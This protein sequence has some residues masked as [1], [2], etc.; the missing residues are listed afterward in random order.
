MNRQLS[1]TALALVA[2]LVAVGCAQGNTSQEPEPYS[3]AMLLA[4]KPAGTNALIIRALG[5]GQGTVTISDPSQTCVALDWDDSRHYS[6]VCWAYVPVTTASVTVAAEASITSRFTGWGTGPCAGSTETSCVV[7]MEKD[8]V[9]NLRFDRAG[10]TPRSE[11]VLTVH[12]LGSIDGE[13][14]APESVGLLCAAVER[15]SFKQ[16]CTAVVPNTT[17]PTEVTLT[18]TPSVAGTEFAGWGGNCSGTGTC[19]VTVDRDIGVTAGFARTPSSQAPVVASFSASPATIATGGSAT[20]SWSVTNATS[21]RI[22]PGIGVVTGS[23]VAVA[24]SSTTTYTLTA[25]NAIGTT[26]RMATVTVGAAPRWVSIAAHTS[27]SA[28]I[29]SDQTLWGWGSN[30]RG[31]IGDGTRVSRYV[32][33]LVGSGFSAVSLGFYHSVAL[34]TDGTVWAWGWNGLGTVGDGTTIE[35]IAPVLVGSGFSAIAAGE[36]HSF[37]LRPD[38][39]MWGWGYNEFGQLGDGT[40]TNRLAPVPL[41]TGFARVAAGYHHSVAIKAD[42]TLWSWGDNMYGQL[43]DGSP[44][45]TLPAQVGADTN[46][47]SVAAGW[48]HTAAIKADGSLWTWGGNASG[49]LG[50]GTTA[51]RSAPARVGTGYASVSVGLNHTAAIK[52]DGTLWTWGHNGWGQLGD[53]TKTTRTTPTQVGTGFVAVAAGSS[54]TL[55]LKDDGTLWSWGNNASGQLGDGTTTQRS[56]PGTV[57][58]TSTVAPVATSLVFSVEPQHQL[59]N[60]ARIDPPVRVTVLDQY[61]APYTA[62]SYPITISITGMSIGS[63]TGTTTVDSALGV[64]TFADLEVTGTAVRPR[65][66]AS[67]PGLEVATSGAFELIDGAPVAL[68]LSL[69][70]PTATA[71]EALGDIVVSATNA[72]GSPVPLTEPVTLSV[73]SGPAGGA[74]I[75][76]TTVDPVGGV[77]TFSGIS[78]EVAGDYVL[79][80][81]SGS[82]VVNGAVTV[83]PAV[84]DTTPPWVFI[85]AP[86]NDATVPGSFVLTASVVDDV[87]VSDLHLVV[88]GTQIASAFVE[89]PA[90]V[91]SA[92]VD[93]LAAGSHVLQVCAV[94]TSGNLGCSSD[95]V[96]IV[97]S[98]T[99]SFTPTGSLATQRSWPVAA[100]LADGRVLVM[101][102]RFDGLPLLPS[103]ADAELYDPATGTFTPTGSLDTPRYGFTATLL[104][105]GRVLVLGG[106]NNLNN[107]GPLSSAE[108]YDPASGVFTPAGNMT[109]PRNHHSATLLD[110]GR[111]LIAGTADYSS[112][113]LTAVGSAELFDPT[114]GGFTPTG[115]M[116]VARYFHTATLLPSGKVFIA[117]GAARGVPL[118]V[119]DALPLADAELYDPATG[120]FSATGTMGVERCFHSATM[121]PSG[122]VLIAGGAAGFTAELYDPATG[123]LAVTGNLATERFEHTATLLADGTV[124]LAGGSDSTLTNTASAELF[125][126]DLGSFTPTGSMTAA[127]R[128]HHAAS[129]PDGAVLVVGGGEV[130]P[131]AE[132]YR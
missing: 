42:G 57:G 82:A 123:T 105:D 28:A 84:S 112:R 120:S 24:P 51:G 55:A 114:T 43:G 59:V 129:L 35:R 20:L 86:G 40:T 52:T 41:G 27:H 18:A 102:G 76:T 61:G 121:L 106:L 19:T 56:T 36:G 4:M 111:V 54:H 65:L 34:E 126:P 113:P 30:S 12:V 100:A 78:I 125:V 130:D 90:N 87:G 68:Q 115:S 119:A 74:L 53:G 50:D 31:E 21:V 103:S 38:G 97:G 22:D 3:D 122:K 1:S 75:G 69:A 99:G 11:Y 64:A 72:T 60:G 9:M 26:T 110:D 45:R 104:R 91:F 93:T 62:G 98:A 7:P 17:P 77:A 63:L 132:L 10:P 131:D 46:W 88:D 118:R 29:R 15:V 23:S 71:G 2:A 14:T 5:Y 81:T 128:A 116:V 124:L 127:R 25:S 70:S 6:Q 89:G 32:P 80:A 108:I 83:D 85:T 73:L 95:V 79:Q 48:Y 16:A 101:G 96:V 58:V 67:S 49:Q 117:G 33:V 107:G 66:V 44:G 92:T 47:S 37:A 13:I 39:S 109:M 8:R 94:D